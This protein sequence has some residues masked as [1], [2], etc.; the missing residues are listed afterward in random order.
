M[1]AILKRVNGTEVTFELP[2]EPDLT[3]IRRKMKGHIKAEISWL[4]GRMITQKQRG[5]IF[6]LIAD[7]CEHTGHESDYIEQLLKTY[8][9]ILYGLET[10][11]LSNAKCTIQDANYFIETIIQFC[12]DHDIMFQ[13]RKYHIDG[14]T[15]RILFIYLMNR[16]C[17]V[18]GKPNADI[19]HVEAVGAG[20]NRNTIDHTEHR[21]LSLSREYHTEQHLIGIDTFMEKYHLVPIKLN[22]EQIR[23][24]GI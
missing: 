12:F 19:A 22:A 15:Q 24:L 7:I 17:M 5:L 14:N 8:H 23:E 2:A 9:K 20:R 11:S 18:S 3:N 6:G 21:F 1:D 10:F 13:N 16:A 4:D